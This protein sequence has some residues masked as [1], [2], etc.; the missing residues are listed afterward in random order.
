M[1]EWRWIVAGS[2]L[3]G[4]GERR[5]FEAASGGGMPG[6]ATELPDSLKAQAIDLAAR[7]KKIEAIKL[8]R[9]TMGWDLRQAKEA[10]EELAYSHLSPGGR[11]PSEAH[12]DVPANVLA[13]AQGLI[14]KRRTVEAVALIR[15]ATGW[16]LADA[17]AYVDRMRPYRP[18]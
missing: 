6:R 12:G 11:W 13:Q 4:I 1:V 5:R 16:S 10:V 7:G 9:E 18:E 15:R 14:D 3:I 17:K 2:I 8:V